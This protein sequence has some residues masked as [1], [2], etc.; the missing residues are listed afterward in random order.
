MGFMFQNEFSQVL[1]E[2]C[3]LSGR[4]AGWRR[5]RELGEPHTAS[6]CALLSAR[7]QAHICKTPMAACPML[8][9]AVPPCQPQHPEEVRTPE[10]VQMRLSREFGSVLFHVPHLFIWAWR[11]YSG[12]SEGQWRKIPNPGHLFHFMVGIGF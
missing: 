2:F 9:K 12:V 4:G 7:S 11:V 3:T 5:G 8:G 6:H 10:M 1:E